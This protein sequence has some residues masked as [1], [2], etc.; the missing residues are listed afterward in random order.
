MARTSLKPAGERMEIVLHLP[1][2][3][4]PIRAVGEVRWVRLYSERSNVPPG[5][6]IK[7][8]DLPTDSAS[9]IDRFLKDREPLFYDDEG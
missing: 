2:R 3:E 8:V 9:A 6:G 7:F 4:E 5:M 1:D